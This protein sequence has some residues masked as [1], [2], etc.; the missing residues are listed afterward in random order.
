MQE[1]DQLKQ[2]VRPDRPQSRQTQDSEAVL[3]LDEDK[4]DEFVSTARWV[5]LTT[6]LSLI[7]DPN[8][9]DIVV[10]C[11]RHYLDTLVEKLFRKKKKKL[12]HGIT[13]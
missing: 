6:H 8:T 13:W 5:Q 7:R 12:T 1:T 2:Q 4:F 10:T 9:Q 11:T 3:I